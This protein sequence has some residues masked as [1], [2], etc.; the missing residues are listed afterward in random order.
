MVTIGIFWDNLVSNDMEVMHV[1]YF[2]QTCAQNIIQKNRLKSCALNGRRMKL[3]TYTN[4]IMQS[5]GGGEHMRTPD[6]RAHADS[7]ILIKVRTRIIVHITAST[8]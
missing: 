3:P 8:L 5:L 2:M 1:S 6:I 7:M 4:Y